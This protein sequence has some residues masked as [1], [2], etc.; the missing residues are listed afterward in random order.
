[1][2]SVWNYQLV[3]AL[4]VTSI[5]FLVGTMFAQDRVLT[6]TAQ[7]GKD[8]Q[9]QILQLLRRLELS[10]TTPALAVAWISGLFLAVSSGYFRSNWLI[11]KLIFV[12]ALSALHGMQSGQVRRA[13][14]DGETVKPHRGTGVIIIVSMLLIAILV[15]MKPF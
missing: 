2:T 15:T 8:Q 14:R 9:K 3:I 10:V 6:G 13:L 11:A 5:T 7:Q 4:H 1:M 12:I